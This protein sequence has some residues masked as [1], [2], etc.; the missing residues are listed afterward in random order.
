VYKA[1]SPSRSV[2]AWLNGEIGCAFHI[3]CEI[4]G[5][6]SRTLGNSYAYVK[7]YAKKANLDLHKA[8]N[9][10]LETLKAF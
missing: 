9:L 10:V 6:S 2:N 8:L 1:F 4:V 5:I 3:L 7:Y